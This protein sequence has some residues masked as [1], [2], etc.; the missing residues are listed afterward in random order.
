MEALKNENVTIIGV[1][2]MG[3]C[4]KTTMVEHVCI[5]AQKIRLFDKVIKADITHNL[6]VRNF[7][8]T[9]AEM[10]GF[11]PE[12]ETDYGRKFALRKMMRRKRIL[13]FL[14]DIW[15]KIRLSSIGIPSPCELQTCNSKVIF[16]TRSMT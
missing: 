10:L 15:D 8:D 12:K 4:G 7:Q 9:F 2:G 16:T 3:G 6:D 14:D 11:E 1:Y 5:E 13:I